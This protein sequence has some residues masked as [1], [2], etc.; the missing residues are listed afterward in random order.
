MNVN[1]QVFA[2]IV[3]LWPSRDLRSTCRYGQSASVIGTV[4]MR[5]RGITAKKSRR[6]PPAFLFARDDVEVIAGM[7]S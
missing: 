4:S 6:K 5:H 1:L 2:G 3:G 7:V